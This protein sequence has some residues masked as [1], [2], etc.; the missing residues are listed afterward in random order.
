MNR[1]KAIFCDNEGC[2][3]PG[4]GLPFPLR[5]FIRLRELF[6]ACPGVDFSVCTGRSVPYV[7]GLVQ[8]LD[9]LNSTI[10]CVCEGGAVL[11]WPKSDR[12][13]ALSSLSDKEELLRFLRPDSYRVEPG[14][15]ACLSL[16]A[17]EKFTLEELYRAITEGSTPGAYNITMS[18]VAVDVTPSG[19]DKGYGV[20]EA[21]RRVSISLSEVLCIGDSTNDMPMLK[22]GGYSACPR[23]ATAEVK[24]SVDFVAPSESTRGLLEILEHFRPHFVT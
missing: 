14:K 8:A 12:W 1:I 4:K 10:P 6:N 7:E 15:V 24:K 11:Y 18:A 19:I 3:S 13:E 16:Y 17:A 2:I 5:D 9:L 20:Q 21:C 23:N 22:I